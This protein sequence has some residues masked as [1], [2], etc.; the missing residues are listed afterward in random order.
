MSGTLA[1]RRI[2]VTGGGQG[3][4][5]GIARGLAA[6]GAD[7]VVTDLNGDTAHAV[8]ASIRAAGGSADSRELDVRDERAVERVFAHVGLVDGL[9]NN[10]GVITKRK[11]VELDLA[12]FHQ[13]VS[14]NLYGYFLCAREAAKALIGAGQGGGIVNICSLGAH[15]GRPGFVHYAASKGGILAMTRALAV[16]LAPSGIRVNTV[17]P[18]VMDTP[19]NAELT[20]SPGLVELSLAAIPI[21]RLGVPDD[22]VGVVE[23]LLSERSSW[24]T[25]ADFIVDGGERASGPTFPASFLEQALAA[26]ATR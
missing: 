18:G 17:S 26:D 13:V 4:G 15:R 1:G 9:V 7:V 12:E 10:A 8:A 22:L 3:N 5:E 19:M 16:E 24:V 21:G 14:V 6:A 2:L 11:F 20:A 23:F 25:G